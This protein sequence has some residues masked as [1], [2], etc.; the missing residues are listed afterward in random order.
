MNSDI[1]DGILL[2]NKPQW[3]TSHDVISKLRKLWR[4]EKIGHAGT[5]DPMA[6][7][8]LIVLI[9]RATKISQQ[10]ITLPKCYGGTMKLG[11]STDSH[12]IEGTV[13]KTGEVKGITM[14]NIQAM[15]KEFIGEQQQIPPMFSAKKING[16]KLYKLARK[17][18]TIEREP[19]LI[20]VDK[21]EIVDFSNDEVK[22]FIHCSKGTYV[23]TIVNDFG[24]RLQCGAHLIQLCRT[25]IGDFSLGNALTIEQIT[26]MPP[27]E[28]A[29]QLVILRESFTRK[30]LGKKI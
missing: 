28:L 23:R 15:A 1:L 24:E 21:F 18:K 27:G 2:V 29:R 11:A 9:G 13:I 4:I 14:E 5:L 30:F 25:A 16:Q 26:A 19:Q 8:L 22:F 3:M 12:D 20:S 6:T 10:L 7:G 17:G